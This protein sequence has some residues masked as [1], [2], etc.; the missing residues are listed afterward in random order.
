LSIM[1]IALARERLSP[2]SRALTTGS[3]VIYYYVDVCIIYLSILILILL[4]FTSILKILCYF[5]VNCF[6]LLS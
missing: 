1:E 3:I 2:S 5:N 6:L 4:H